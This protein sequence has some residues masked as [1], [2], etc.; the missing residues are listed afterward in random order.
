MSAA[1]LLQGLSPRLD[2][3]M[4][5]HRGSQ[6]LLCMMHRAAARCL[7]A[8]RPAWLA[9]ACGAARC[10]T[11]STTMQSIERWTKHRLDNLSNSVLWSWQPTPAKEVQISKTAILKT[12]TPGEKGVVFISFES[13]WQKLLSLGPERLAAF[14]KDYQLVLA[15]T[16]S[17]P[18]SPVNLVFPR[19]FP[20]ELTCTISNLTD[21][22]ILPR[23]HPAYQPMPLFA[24]SWVNPALYRPKPRG[25]RDID[26]VMVANFGRYKRHHVLFSALARIPSGKR[27]KVTLIGQPHG[28]RSAAVLQRE[29]ESYGVQDCVTLRSRISDAEVVDAVCRSK[30]AF[31][32]SLREGSC[33]AVVE[34][35]MAD[36]P[37]ALLTGAQIGSSAF[38]NE[39]TGRWLNEQR[40]HDELPTFIAESERYSPR[41]WLLDQGVH[42]HASTDALNTRMRTAAESTGRPWTRSL[43]THHWRPDPVLLGAEDLEAAAQK[44]DRI[45]A[46][47]GLRLQ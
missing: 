39:H 1:A 30:V 21:L 8:N 32:A 23:L 46:R 45:L 24:S 16:W 43:F 27:P 26:L 18:H 44:S 41:T 14:A 15:P 22:E 5:Y 35:M 20:G 6:S 12:S 28:H 38:L 3:L 47:L 31:I 10:A 34:A 40:L 37:V 9:H 42:C 19:L 33:V 25:D 11:S 2:D 36:T 4:R 7:P 17:P 13:Q 29:I